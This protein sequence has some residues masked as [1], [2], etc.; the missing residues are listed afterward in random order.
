MSAQPTNHHKMQLPVPSGT[1]AHA[2]IYAPL[3]SAVPEIRVV[4]LLPSEDFG[5]PIQCQLSNRHSHGEK[6]GYE[7][8]S[9]V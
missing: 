4:K 9:Y 8:L 1:V 5:S 3:D 2:H 6:D 7:A